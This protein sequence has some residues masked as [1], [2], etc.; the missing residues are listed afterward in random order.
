MKRL[1]PVLMGFAL[2]LLSSTE[3]WSA[4]FQKGLDAANKGDFAAALREWKP[5]AEQGNARAQYNLGRMYRRG[6]GVPKNYEIAVKWYRL[7]ADQGNARAQNYLGLMYYKGRGVS[8]DYKMAVKWYKLAA[9]QRYAPAQYN[10]GRIYQRGLGVAKNFKTAV[11]W[12]TLAAEQGNAIAQYTLGTAYRRGFGVLKNQKTA[13]KWWRLAAKQ[14]HARAQKSLAKLEKLIASKKTSPT[15]T[16]Q[17]S[18]PKFAGNF[19]KGLDDA[20]REG[21]RT[22]LQEWKPPAE[23]GDVKAPKL[24]FFESPISEIKFWADKGDPSSQSMLGSM[25]ESGWRVKEDIKKA[26][27]YLTKAADG[28]NR[29]AQHNLALLFFNNKKFPRDIKKAIHYWTLEA[30]NKR[31]DIS[32]AH[33][34]AAIYLKGEGV[35]VNHKL[36]IKWLIR[37]AY[38]AHAD[39]QFQLAI[40]HFKGEIVEENTNLGLYFLFMAVRNGYRKAFQLLQKIKISGRIPA[41]LLRKIKTDTHE[42]IESEYRN[43]LLKNGLFDAN[44]RAGPVSY[45]E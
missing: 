38:R 9:N 36:G 11:K 15:V 14:G 5:L 21:F 17:K 7:A 13:V 28:G 18:S 10:L 23:Q 34:L 8:Q 31:G 4:D 24:K 41:D 35:P 6:D 32:G 26:I 42:C 2:L 20:K 16:S 44:G 22:A 25:Y 3:G 1:L 33:N 45:L 40:I 19:K 27:E 12:Y 39:D 30:Q 37:S 43:C 29:E